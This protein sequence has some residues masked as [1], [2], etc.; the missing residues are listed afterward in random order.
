MRGVSRFSNH[1]LIALAIGLVVLVCLLIVALVVLQPWTS[2]GRSL[3][4][5]PTVVATT[6]PSVQLRALD[7]QL[8]AVGAGTLRPWA[9]MV[10]NHP[11]ARPPAGLEQASVVYEAV[12][13]GG[14]TRFLALVDPSVDLAKLGPIRSARPY[15]ARWAAEYSALYVH[16]GGSPEALELLDTLGVYNVEE[17]SA[18]GVY[19]YRDPKRAA[20]HNL[21]TSADRLRQF[22]LDRG[23]TPS[24]DFA[25]WPRKDDQPRALRPVSGRAVKVRFSTPAFTATF[26]Y[27]RER[28]AYTRWQGTAPHLTADGVTLEAKNVIIQHVQAQVTDA[29]GRREVGTQTGGRVE[30]FTD[31]QRQVGRWELRDGRTWWVDLAGEPIALNV[32][33]TWVEVVDASALVEAVP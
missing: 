30:V 26:R 2:V 28:N 17:I 10:D 9:V 23:I 1:Q 15:F 27:D 18:S 11:D 14:V 13:E 24:V 12:A 7:G 5:A 33:S 25:A 19:F 16:S 20:P 4:S 32:G 21:Y 6:T 31:G 3:V 8:V 29:V 22:T